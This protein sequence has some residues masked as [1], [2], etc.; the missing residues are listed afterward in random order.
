MAFTPL[1]FGTYVVGTGFTD[2]ND[3][4][5]CN[6]IPFL[7]TLTSI[8]GSDINV[9]LTYVDQDDNVAEVATVP[10]VIPASTGNGVFI[11]V[12]LNSGDVG[13]K[14]VVDV[15]ITGGT[16]GNQ[17][18]IVNNNELIAIEI[19][20]EKLEHTDDEVSVL[21]LTG[22]ILGGVIIHPS[23]ITNVVDNAYE[24]L[25]TG[26]VVSA[27][28]LEVEAMLSQAVVGIVISGYVVDQTESVITDAVAVVLES[29]EKPSSIVVG[30]VNP[31]TGFYQ[32][33][34]KDAVYDKRSLIVEDSVSDINIA[35]KKY[36]NVSS[37]DG[38][39]HD[40]PN[41]NMQFW[42]SNVLAKSVAHVDGLVTY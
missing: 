16:A 34:I 4:A 22:N 30:N 32:V 42:V 15:T 39:V 41:Q 25:T 17:F 36:G 2:G 5:E 35:L 27:R 9:T 14:N 12:V 33:A 1:V 40:L 11:P 6:F 31:A 29:S 10:T 24:H 7:K 23:M 18:S 19:G 28:I 38:R 37:Y 21:F 13:I 26:T 8:G 20:F 3:I